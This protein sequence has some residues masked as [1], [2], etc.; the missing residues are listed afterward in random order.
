LGVELFVAHL[1]GAIVERLGVRHPR[2]PPGRV[3]A[4]AG[5]AGM[6]RPG[7]VTERRRRYEVRLMTR[8]PQVVVETTLARVGPAHETVDGLE[9]LALGGQR[10][11]SYE[12]VGQPDAIVQR[13][14]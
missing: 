7:V 6:I 11:D 3:P 2:E 9:S 12:L 4:E 13:L 14:V 5:D 1:Q 10:P 8:P